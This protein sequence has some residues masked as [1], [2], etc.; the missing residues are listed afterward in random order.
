MRRAGVGLAEHAAPVGG[1]GA[2]VGQG[3]LALLEQPVL[4]EHAGGGVRVLIRRRRDDD[5]HVQAAAACM[6]R[7]LSVLLNE[8]PT[9]KPSPTCATSAPASNLPTTSLSTWLAS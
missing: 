8:R 5:V 2:C 7:Q 6:E 1:R 4:L 3:V 9:S